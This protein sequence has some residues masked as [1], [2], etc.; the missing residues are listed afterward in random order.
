L[1]KVVLGERV[2]ESAQVEERARRAMSG[3]ASL[4]VGEGD[5]V[6]LLMRNDIAFLE[7][8]LALGRLGAYAVP[9]NWHARPD[10]IRAILLDSGAKAVI[11]HDDL[12]RA[13]PDVPTVLVR[14]PQQIADAYG[15][16]PQGREVPTG[17]PEWESWL[18]AHSPFAAAPRRPRGSIVYT[19]GT[20]G[21]PKGIQREPFAS[22]AEEQQHLRS[23]YQTFGIRPG[24]R[25]LICG[26]LY[27]SMQTANMRAAFNALGED[28]L[29]VIEPRF[30]AERLL[31][32]IGQ[33]RITQILMVP[34]M[35]VRLLRLPDEV[36]RRYDVSSLEWVVHS[37]AP[38]PLEVKRRMIEWF[39][40][41]IHE[42]YA[43]SE[44]GAVTLIG[45]QDALDRPGS[46]GRALPG[47]TVKVL[48][49]S[50]RG[51][52]PRAEGEIA[53][54][55]HAYPDFTY[56]NRP[57]ARAALD[58]GGLV[59]T[60]DIGYFD[61][62][63][64]LFLC[65]RRNDMVISGGANIFPADIEEVLLACPGVADCAVFGIPD[66]EYGE[67]LA[68]HVEPIPGA[69][70]HEAGVRAYLRDR[71]PGFKVPR[72]IRFEQALP[73]EDSGKI[74]KRRLREPYWA[75]ARS[76]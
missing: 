71:L 67:V 1:G 58:R 51:L 36:R 56:R 33:H 45:P 14:T 37:A 49:G 42:F 70:L 43:A 44:L 2:L 53:A 63:G 68:A 28:G 3:L 48:D 55:N 46:V 74:F 73:R 54:V 5:A 7:A 72:V 59:A 39:G 64:F 16:E 61:E 57:E 15:L 9:L 11:A 60:G 13:L 69:E 75:A 24:V 10:E 47:C 31:R 66:E 25:A 21:T 50:G 41:V 17:M 23:L 34:V 35:F 40:P 76:A 62:Q 19:S 65:G 4:G 8:S 27:H 30:D 26:P 20:T 52:P 12:A 32:T 22:A 38:C 6:A 29:L 18:G